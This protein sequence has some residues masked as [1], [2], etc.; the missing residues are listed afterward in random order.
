MG[1]QWGNGQRMFGCL[2]TSFQ[3]FWAFLFQVFDPFIF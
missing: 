3:M 2:N 1:V